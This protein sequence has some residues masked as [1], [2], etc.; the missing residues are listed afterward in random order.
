MAD[1]N[2]KLSVIRLNIHILNI[3]IRKH[4]LAKRIKNITGGSI[5]KSYK[6]LVII[7]NI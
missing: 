6:G 4:I 1:I 5:C 2:A 3:P 7:Q